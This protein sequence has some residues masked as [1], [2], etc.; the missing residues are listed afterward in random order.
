MATTTIK[1]ITKNTIL[2]MSTIKAKNCSKTDVGVAAVLFEIQ[3]GGK[4]L[5]ERFDAKILVSQHMSFV[6]TFPAKQRLQLLQDRSQQT[7][8]VH[9][10]FTDIINA[11]VKNNFIIEFTK[12][13]V[14]R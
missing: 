8:L 12:A 9:A 11:T 10:A 13:S 5:Q 3:G 6:V 4:V 7:K 2:G 1:Q 14:V